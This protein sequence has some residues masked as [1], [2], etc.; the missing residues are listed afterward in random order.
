MVLGAD[1]KPE[2]T[3]AFRGEGL[4][5]NFNR[6]PAVGSSDHF[7]SLRPHLFFASFFFLNERAGELSKVDVRGG[8]KGVKSGLWG[9]SFFHTCKSGG[10]LIMRGRFTTIAALTACLH[11]SAQDDSSTDA[12]LKKYTI[13]AEGINASYIAYGA[14]LTNLYVKDRDGNFQDVVMGYDDGAGYVNDTANEHTYFGATG[15]FTAIR[16]PSFPRRPRSCRASR[17]THIHSKINK[18]D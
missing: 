17:H 18:R 7:P 6:N 13:S 1:S 3:T 2:G 11:A 16:L 4:R 8:H 10:G 9:I 12:N 14:T 5:L 15:T